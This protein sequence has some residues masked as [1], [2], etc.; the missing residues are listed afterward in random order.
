M[1]RKLKSSYIMLEARI[2]E[3]RAIWSSLRKAYMNKH[4]I[5]FMMLFYVLNY[6]INNKFKLLRS[7]ENTQTGF[8]NM[9][10]LGFE[11]QMSI[12]MHNDRLSKE[13]L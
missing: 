7:N 3:D 2:A 13:I 8:L 11:S 5:G 9:I 4:E 12:L 1:Q 10:L 6:V